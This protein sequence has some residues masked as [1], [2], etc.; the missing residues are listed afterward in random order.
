MIP[1]IIYFLFTCTVTSLWGE[2]RGSDARLLSGALRESGMPDS[3]ENVTIPLSYTFAGLTAEVLIDGKPEQLLLDTGASTTALSVETAEKHGLNEKVPIANGESSTGENI[4]ATFALT[5]RISIGD[6]WTKNEPV[7]VTRILIPGINGVLGVGTLADWDV[8][9]NPL[10]KKLIL[11]PAG[12]APPLEG[13]TVVPLISQLVNPNSSISNQQGLRLLNLRVPVS[14]G[15]HKLMVIPDTGYGGILQLSQAL[16]EK[17]APGAMKESL[18]SL[19]TGTNI[20]GGHMS[21]I[22][23]IPLFTFGPNTLRSLPASVVGT[24]VGSDRTYTGII[25]LN[26]LRHYVM[27]FSFS[28]GELRLK[29]IGT[30][31]EITQSSTAGIFLAPGEGGRIFIGDVIP[32][33]PAGQVG[34]RAGDEL[35]E[36]EGIP[37]KTMKQEEFEAFKK[38]PPGS[39]VKV[40]YSR[41]D[42]RPTKVTLVLVKK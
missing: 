36:I 26:L 40:I 30:V 20:S 11:Y 37:L 6:A 28:A 25:G 39:K 16:T 34:L 27:T 9:I 31:Q 8:R 7:I 18:P 19:A 32:N 14:V 35:L 22:T 3:V 5:K 10:T 24:P 21:R 17:V 23:K 15:D 4:E 1:R 38:L 2:E 12:K 42:E 33:G 29:P 13:E 41:G